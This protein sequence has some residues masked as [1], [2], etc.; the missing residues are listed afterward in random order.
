MSEERKLIK[1][2][3]GNFS[4]NRIILW[5]TIMHTTVYQ[6]CSSIMCTSNLIVRYNSS[7]IL[8]SSG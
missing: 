4:I 1:A 6:A 2:V 3:V 8:V 5:C 7:Q